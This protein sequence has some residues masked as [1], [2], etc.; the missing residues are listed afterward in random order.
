MTSGI[1]R[2]GADQLRHVA[3]NRTVLEKA[4]EAS[5]IDWEVLAGVWY[6]ES[7]SVSPPRTPGGCFQFDPPPDEPYIRW[8]LGKFTSLPRTEAEDIAAA[9]V[10]A[11]ADGAY[12]AAAFLRMKTGLKKGDTDENV[13]NTFWSYNGRFYGSA[14][15]SPYVMNG[16]D[17]AHLHMKIQ[18]T[19]PP[20]KEGGPRRKI[21]TVDMRPGAFVVYK[22]LKGDI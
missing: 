7:F 9:G 16:Y 13:K 18:G 15:A 5:S 4:A 19:L 8:M 14:D 1:L 17:A 3:L 12:I 6:R 2:L 20:L 22:Q 21:E 11:F 10:N